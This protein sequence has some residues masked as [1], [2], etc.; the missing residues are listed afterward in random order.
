[1]FDTDECNCLGWN[2]TERNSNEADNKAVDISRSS[3]LNLHDYARLPKTSLVTLC[4][5]CSISAATYLRLLD[6]LN[7]QHY[8]G[9]NADAVVS[10]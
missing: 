10:Q 7:H 2:D 1:V 6:R 8:H 3:C 4:N 9:R 5:P